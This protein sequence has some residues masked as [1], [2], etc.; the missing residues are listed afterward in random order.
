M[1]SLIINNFYFKVLEYVSQAPPPSFLPVTFNDQEFSVK[2]EF[3]GKQV[4]ANL[5][6][7]KQYIRTKLP[8]AKISVNIME[9]CPISFLMNKV[10]MLSLLVSLLF[11]KVI[12]IAFFNPM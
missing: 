5:I 1:Y 9:K 11:L 4:S 3:K 6:L 7:D 8:G 10:M 12:V 2:Y